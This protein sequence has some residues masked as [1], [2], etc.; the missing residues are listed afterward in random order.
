M[1]AIGVLILVTACGGAQTRTTAPPVEDAPADASA[2]VRGVVQEAYGSLGH[3]NREGILPLLADHVYVIGPAA[4]DLLHER[5]DVV[6]ALTAM[7]PAEKKHK[8]ASHALRAVVSPGG[9]SAYVSDQ[10]DVDGVPYTASA[11]MEQQGGM[12]VAT[13]IC[14]ARALP[15]ARQGKDPLPSIVSSVDAGARGAVDAFT[16]AAAAP[17][18]FVEQLADG[19]EVIAIGPGPRDVLRGGAAI[20]KAWKKALKKHPSLEVMGGV[21]AGVT[22]DGQLAWIHANVTRGAD[23]SDPSVRRGF[24]VYA[25]DG[26]GWRLTAAHESA[27]FK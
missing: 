25:H 19:P 3:G 8:I 17:A 10:L 4:N 2:E 22:P 18:L 1:R 24:Y 27:A 23:G 9:A 20:H 6:V 15:P 16:H 5:S 12:W 13:A 7:F 11:V 21:R 14:V 26:A